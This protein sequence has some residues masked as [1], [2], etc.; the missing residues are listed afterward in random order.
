MS[1]EKNKNVKD[2]FITKFIDV[3]PCVKK[4]EFT[5][6]EEVI[7]SEVKKLSKIFAK[8]INI[9]GFRVGKAPF[10]LIK[11]KYNKELQQELTK[12]LFNIGIELTQ[13][14]ELDIVAHETPNMED[15]IF[16][17]DKECAFSFTVNISPDVEMGEYKGLK[18]TSDKVEI[19]KENVDEILKGYRESYPTF[20][21][22]KDKSEK[23]DIIKVAYSS[24]FKIAEDSTNVALKTQVNSDNLI[25]WEAK[26]ELIPGMTECLI[27][28]EIN[29]EYDLVVDYSNDF[30]L[31]DL[32]GQKVTYKIKVLSIQ[33]QMPASDEEMLKLFKVDTI[34]MVYKEIESNMHSQQKAQIK[35]KLNKDIIGQLVDTVKDFDC[36]PL[37]IEQEANKHINIIEKQIKNKDKEA[38]DKF[39]AEKD[40]LLEKAKVDVLPRLKEVFIIRKIALLENIVITEKMLDK[41]I[42][43][44]ANHY[45]KGKSKKEIKQIKENIINNGGAEDVKMDMLQIEVCNFIIENAT[46]TEK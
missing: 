15:M 46:I 21:D 27:G 43:A 11:K 45:G 16:E 33:R 12:V 26:N 42:S 4:I 7:I 35:Q 39:I 44:I 10:K 29:K 37:V 30:K 1:K 34:E 18:L 17:L 41:E 22:I 6:P 25:V 14:S 38:A 20:V 9:P 23:D 13:D 3:A 36:P 24:D 19:K 8:E 28:C 32:S 2:Q 31:E 40:S 5:V